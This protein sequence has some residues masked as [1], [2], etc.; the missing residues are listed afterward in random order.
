VVHLD[1]AH[2][3]LLI[4]AG[5]AAGAINAMAGGG[6]LISFPALL[7]VGYSPLVANVT[8]TVALVPGYVGGSLAYRVE[9]R[10]QGQALRRLGVISLAGGLVGAILLVAGPASVFKSVVPWLILFSCALLLVQPVIKR[11]L[12]GGTQTGRK[13][14]TALSVAQFLASVY[15]GYFGAGLGVLMLAV[16]G[17]FL[18]D[19]LQRV[20]AL[21][22]LL[23][24]IINLISAIFFAV[25]APV[26]WLPVLIMAAASL[27]GGHLGVRLARKLSNEVLRIFVI[28]FG[29]AVAIKLLV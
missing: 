8:N 10:D 11:W 28:A 26:A 29:V 22:G 18:G 9:L 20:N 25:F 24:L 12:Q 27:A 13:R 14:V 5:V 16:L 2:I 15:G 7:A 1:A 19:T 3:L 17:M 21:K 4:G 6:S 23:S